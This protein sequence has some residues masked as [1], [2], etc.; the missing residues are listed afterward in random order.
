[1]SPSRAAELS[2]TFPAAQKY[3]L[4]IRSPDGSERLLTE[5]PMLQNPQF[6]PTGQRLVVARTSAH[7]RDAGVVDIRPRGRPTR[8]QADGRWRTGASL[9]ARWRVD[10]LLAASAEPATRHLHQACRRTR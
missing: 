1:M 8:E 4:V 5:D 7:R 9:G 10:Y 2:R 6:S 3:A